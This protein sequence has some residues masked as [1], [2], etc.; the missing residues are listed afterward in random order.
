MDLN[1]CSRSSKD[2]QSCPGGLDWVFLLNLLAIENR[3]DILTTIYPVI[4]MHL[5]VHYL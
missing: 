3:K 4:A 5:D 2:N 1:G